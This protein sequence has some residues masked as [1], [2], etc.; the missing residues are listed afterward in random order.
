MP[1]RISR[2]AIEE[3]LHTLYDGVAL[4]DAPIVP[5]FPTIAAIENVLI[6]ARVLRHLVLDAIETLQPPGRAGFHSPKTRSYRVLSMRYLEGCSV[7]QIAAELHMSQRQIYRDLENAENELAQLLSTQQY[8]V[9]PAQQLEAQNQGRPLRNELDRVPIDTATHDVA[10]LLESALSTVRPL[11]ARQNVGIILDL[12]NE[13]PQAQVCADLLRQ[14]LIL[15]LSAA[16]RHTQDGPVQV[17]L[18]HDKGGID[19]SILF[20]PRGHQEL[21][22]DLA[23]V[24]DL[25]SAQGL[26]WEEKNLASGRFS[27]TFELSATGRTILVVEDNRSTVALY[28]R[29]LASSTDWQL[30]AVED[31]THAYA[32]AVSKQPDLILLDIMMPNTDG[33]TLLQTLKTQPETKQIRV[34]VCTV[35]GEEALAESLGAD[36]YIKKPVTQT[37]FLQALAACLRKDKAP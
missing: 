1:D 36:G 27:V 9:S 26:D 23:N 5:H 18:G 13:R 31:P 28:Q 35:F 29:F 15:L 6:R 16:I 20:R 2:D 24:R 32:E 25:A 12:G 17:L 10:A 22:D 8:T 7:V 4:A 33:W 37:E 11:A 34:L 21:E 3:T 30:I 19:L 14:M